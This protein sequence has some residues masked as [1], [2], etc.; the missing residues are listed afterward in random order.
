LENEKTLFSQAKNEYQEKLISFTDIL[1]KETITNKSINQLHN[2]LQEQINLL[3]QN[4]N[5]NIDQIKILEVKNK[6]LSLKLEEVSIEKEKLNN[7]ESLLK[8]EN[9]LIIQTKDKTISELHSQNQILLKEKDIILQKNDE[10]ISI[11]QNRL[12]DIQLE[13]DN[14]TQIKDESISLLQ[15]QIKALQTEKD[16]K[17]KIFN[18]KYIASK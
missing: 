3:K 1:E 9:D 4:E 18:I 10:N 16:E 14:S 12:H 2:S 17:M 13:K 5:M 6:E 8:V 15:H 11:L 7:N